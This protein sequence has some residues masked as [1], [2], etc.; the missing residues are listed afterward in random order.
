MV[1]LYGFQIGDRPLSTPDEGRYAEIPRAMVETGDYITPRLNGVK[2]FEKPALMYWLVSGSIR[3]FG[4]HEASLRL[5]PVLF[6]ILSCL[7]VYGTARI[8]YG[9]TAGIW[10]AIPLATCLYYAGHSQILILDGALSCFMTITL[11]GFLLAVKSVKTSHRVVALSLFFIAAA[12]A[13]L[14]KGLIGIALPGCIILLWMALTRQG[15]FLS[16]A[17][18]PWGIGLFLFITVPWH[19]L[20]SLKNPEFPHF[21]FVHEHFL[22]YTTT[23][24]GRKQFFGFFAPILILGW[25]PWIGF[26]GQSVK[27]F[28]SLKK[29]LLREEDAFLFLG[30]WAAFIFLFFSISRSQ[31]IPYILP[32]FPPLAMILGCTI[33]LAFEDKKSLLFKRGMQIYL[34][35][36]WGIAILIPVVLYHQKIHIETALWLPVVLT[37]SLLSLGSTVSFFRFKRGGTEIGLKWMTLNQVLL[38]FVLVKA[39]P[40]LEDRSIKPLAQIIK[41]VLKGDDVVACYHRYYQDLPVYLNRRV[42][43]VSWRGELE[44]GMAQED[45]SA[46][47]LAEKDFWP[48]WRSPKKVYLLTRK[49]IYHDLQH[50]QEGPFYQVSATHE[51]VLLTNHPGD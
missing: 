5:W 14:T 39:W 38:F 41:P 35:F 31:L 44:F 29:K 45:T 11:C 2:Y 7:F 28:L 36:S 40:M 9:R 21:Y 42:H 18:S 47:M 23:I 16:Y 43:V 10:S 24:H 19:V 3:L 22:R 26:L 48:L 1:F 32:V 4:V 17:F 8:L 51:D 13:T 33:A 50:K 46:W 37:M 49:K 34:I 6:A 12:C 25:F 30:V 15:K 27:T 20:V